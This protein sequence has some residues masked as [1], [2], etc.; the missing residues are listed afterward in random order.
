[1]ADTFYR[2]NILGQVTHREALIILVD[3]EDHLIESN[4]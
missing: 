4:K 1:V 3:V 2:I